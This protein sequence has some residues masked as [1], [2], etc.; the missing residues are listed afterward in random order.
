MRKQLIDLGVEPP[1]LDE[2]PLAI[3]DFP[4]IVH[5]AFDIFNQLP[6]EYIPRM[7]AP[8]FYS[9]K[10]LECLEMMFNLHYISSVEEKRLLIELINIL[11]LQARKDLNKARPRK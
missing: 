5:T 6:D 11:D 7:D 1:G 10:N 9:G 8:P 3:E 2:M 4:S